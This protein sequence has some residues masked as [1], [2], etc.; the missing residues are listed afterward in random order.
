MNG[1]RGDWQPA[2]ALAVH[3]RSKGWRI[4]IFTNHQ[5]HD[6]NVELALSFQLDVET[7]FSLPV[8]YQA[9]E[10]FMPHVMLHQWNMTPFCWVAEE[11][12]GIPAVEYAFWPTPPWT[13]W[14]RFLEVFLNKSSLD[15]YLGR[16]T[17]P[18]LSEA[19]VFDLLWRRRPTLYAFSERIAPH[20]G[21]WPAPGPRSGFHLTGYW[22][23]EPDRQRDELERA[24][25]FFGGR[26][27]PRLRAFLEA[28]A[29]PVYMGWGSMTAVTSEV[30]HPFLAQ[31]AVRALLRARKRG[32]ILGSYG[33]MG[34]EVL[35]T[36]PDAQ[37]LLRYSASNV[38]WLHWA[39]HE[40]LMPQCCVL[41]HHGGCSTTATSLRAGRP[42]VVTPLYIDQ[43]YWGAQVAR[44]GAGVRTRPLPTLGAGDLVQ[45]L[46]ACEQP[47]VVE[48]AAVLGA[49]LREDR[50][51]TARAEEWLRAYVRSDGPQASAGTLWL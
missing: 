35:R 16:E 8:V 14:D 1:S 20:Q 21:Y 50:A 37:E 30:S 48:A 23:L 43:F 12:L 31:L 5:H 25:A 19:H 18:E 3:M 22:V 33:D 6:P 34:E 44:T 51:G 24:N 13:A 27:G 38:L 47:A 7:C 28:G 40:W 4:R 15:G 32:I 46:D 36:A 2:V 41:V 29:P 42:T 9:V 10:L 49:Q 39:P 26:C 11:Q 17:L 45:A